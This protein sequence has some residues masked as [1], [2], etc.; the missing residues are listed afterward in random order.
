MRVDPK[1][2]TYIQKIIENLPHITKEIPNIKAGDEPDEMIPRK[3]HRLSEGVTITPQEKIS[4]CL[5][6]AALTTATHCKMAGFFEK[7][8]PKSVKSRSKVKASELA[9]KHN[10]KVHDIKN[11]NR[12][13]AV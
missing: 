10:R 4:V 6:A 11:S 8:F 12:N 9:W 3:I 13:M 1:V 7:R 5:T 2:N